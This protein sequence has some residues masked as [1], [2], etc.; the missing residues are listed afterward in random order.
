MSKDR[1]FLM[2]EAAV[3]ALHLIEESAATVTDLLDLPNSP[4]ARKLVLEKHPLIV[5]GYALLTFLDA[6]YEERF[7]PDYESE[8]G[9]SHSE[10]VL[11]E[12]LTS[13]D[14]AHP[15]HT[16]AEREKAAEILGWLSKISSGGK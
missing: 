5:I 10:R 16:E 4:S 12:W 15:N 1:N 2:D 14:H 9:C 7:P 11:G 8:E 3:A 6:R 13:W